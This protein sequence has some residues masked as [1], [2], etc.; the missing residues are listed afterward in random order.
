MAR[1]AIPDRV[2]SKAA[3]GYRHRSK[4]PIIDFMMDQWRKSD[5]TLADVSRK[6]NLSR[7]TIK[8]WDEGKTQRPHH[9]SVTWFLRALGIEL[10]GRPIV[11]NKKG[12]ITYEIKLA[13]HVAA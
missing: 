5:L 6:S 4:D 1:N 2:F 8:N 13:D 7:T 10:V 9:V 11:G 3:T 12:P